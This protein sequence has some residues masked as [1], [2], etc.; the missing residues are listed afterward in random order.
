M[1]SKAASTPSVGAMPLCRRDNEN[2]RA[3]ER[4]YGYFTGNTRNNLP[5]NP[6]FQMT[7]IFNYELLHTLFNVSW[8]AKISRKKEQNKFYPSGMPVT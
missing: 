8:I 3:R 2:H 4:K 6:S 5:F 7:I 1:G